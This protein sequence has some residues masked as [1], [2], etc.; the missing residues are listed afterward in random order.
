MEISSY[1]IV[2]KIVLCSTP[3]PSSYIVHKRWWDEEEESDD[4]DLF[5]VGAAAVG[6]VPQDASRDRG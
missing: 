1:P 4:V 3:S 2:H 6:G 5:V